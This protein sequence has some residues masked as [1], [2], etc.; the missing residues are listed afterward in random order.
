MRNEPFN[1]GTVS[2]IFNPVKE[3]RNTSGNFYRIGITG[4]I[5]SGK[6][7][8]CRLFACLGIPIY[9]ADSR[10]R[11]LTEN[12]PTIKSRLIDLLGNEVYLPSGEYNR[13]LVASIVF[14]KPD[15]LQALNN[16]IH[17]VVGNDSDKWMELMQNSERFPYA[18]KEAAIMN[19]AGDS[20][21]LDF[22]IAVTAP[23]NIRIE[24]VLKR[25]KHRSEIDIRNIIDRQ[26][27]EE[28]RL[29]IADFVIIND[30]VRPLLSQITSIH[31]QLL[32]R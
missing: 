17:P 25:D 14:E 3:N 26:I 22:V 5:G 16:I 31:R 24:R 6:S 32:K 8:I 19:R 11:R 1:S 23:E 18:I 28:E 29:D 27:S 13:S 7:F 20:N 21:S 10:A 2:G 15:L 30:N 9:D 12:H 4:G